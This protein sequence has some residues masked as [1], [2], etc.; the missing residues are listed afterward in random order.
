MSLKNLNDQIAGK[1][2]ELEDLRRRRM[3]YQKPSDRVAYYA[4]MDEIGRDEEQV[5]VLQKSLDD[6][7]SRADAAGVPRDWR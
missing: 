2:K 7:E 5:K 6:L 3:L 4:L 1:K